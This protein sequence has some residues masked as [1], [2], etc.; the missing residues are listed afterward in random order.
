MYAHP[1]SYMNCVDPLAENYYDVS[2]YACCAGNPV[3]AVDPDG[4]RCRYFDC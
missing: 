3:N 2:P 4:K 1:F